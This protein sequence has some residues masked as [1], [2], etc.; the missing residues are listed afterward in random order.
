[1]TIEAT[2]GA[3]RTL[4]VAAEAAGEVIPLR[5]EDPQAR[6][7]RIGADLQLPPSSEVSK[8]SNSSAES[9]SLFCLSISAAEHTS[10]SSL[11]T[12]VH[13]RPA[14]LEAYQLEQ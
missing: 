6:M 14:D 8:A 5:G 13:E 11:Q 1:M 12:S 7:S 4:Q 10:R 2:P 9:A 3:P